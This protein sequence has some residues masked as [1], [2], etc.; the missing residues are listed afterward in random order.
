MPR[1]SA[2]LPIISKLSDELQ[3]YLALYQNVGCVGVQAFWRESDAVEANQLKKM[4]LQAGLQ[5]D[6]VHGS[7]GYTYDLTSP[8]PAIRARTLNQH[9]EDALRCAALGGSA[10]VIHPSCKI[11][12]DAGLEYAERQSQWGDEVDRAR[13]PFFIESLQH[14]NTIGDETGITFLIENLPGYLWFGHSAPRLA[15]LIRNV[16]SSWLRMCFD[17]GHAHMESSQFGSVAEQLRACLDVV[18]YV[19]IHDNDSTVDSHLMPGEGTIDWKSV[20]EVVQQSPL[21][22]TLPIMLEVF[23]PID[24]LEAMLRPSAG[25]RLWKSL[26]TRE[27]AI[28]SL[29]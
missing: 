10:V 24:E 20:H 7:F 16:D 15:E 13:Q 21:F 9:R 12:K 1:L 28:D 4:V 11:P 3:R 25:L 27:L 2:S 18:A 23:N 5:F 8:D 22:K 17:T 19:H 26:A 14:L 6:S 29:D